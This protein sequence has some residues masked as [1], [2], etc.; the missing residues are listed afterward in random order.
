M[1]RVDEV[2][3]DEIELACIKQKLIRH[4]VS[5]FLLCDRDVSIGFEAAVT[6]RPARNSGRSMTPSHPGP[7]ETS[8]RCAR[9]DILA[10]VT[11][12]WALALEAVQ[13]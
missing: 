10:P 7:Q 5:G 2:V 9:S 3:S 11:P 12:D 1:V 4:D 6:P 13:R 8:L